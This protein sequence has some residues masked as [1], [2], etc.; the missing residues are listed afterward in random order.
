MKKNLFKYLQ[1]KPSSLKRSL[2]KFIQTKFLSLVL[3]CLFI[4][5]ATLTYLSIFTD[6]IYPNIYI[7]DSNVAF[8]TKS[9]AY[10]VVDHRINQRLQQPFV[11][12]NQDQQFTLNLDSSKLNI[13]YS[14]SINEAFAIG[15]TGSLTDKLTAQLFLF[16]DQNHPPRP[17]PKTIIQPEVKLDLEK[18]FN[19]IAKKVYETPQD[20][21]IWL[22][23]NNTPQI[24]PGQTG[25]ELDK[26]QLEQQIK[27]YLIF[28][29]QIATLP[30]KKAEP[31]F[32]EEEAK[33]AQKALESI[34][35]QPLT[36]TYEKEVWTIDVPTLYYLL[37]LDDPKTSLLNNITFSKYLEDIAVKINQQVQEPLFKFNTQA[38][39]VESFQPAQDGRELDINQTTSLITDALN[40]PDIKQITLPV[41]VVK[42][43]IQTAEIN[44]LGIKELL[45]QGVSHF[46]GS[47]ENRIYNVRLTASK[48][49]G[50]LIPP[51]ETF[52]F[53][54]TV[55]DISAATGFKQAY[56]IK[57]GRTVLDDGGGVCQASTTLFRAAL[58]AGL[59]ITDRTA[60]AYRVSY[61]EQGGFG[62][63][64]DA[65]IFHPTVDFKFKNDTASYILVQA[66][67]E[68]TS[69]YIDLYGTSD[70]R[71]AEV[72]KPL[73]S[74]QTPPPPELRQD[75]PALPRGQ[76][77]Q[78]DWS[79]WGAKVAFNRTV[80]KGGETITNETWR[81]NYKPW[82]AVYLI[83]TKD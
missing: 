83:G 30:L 78:V 75:D 9:Q 35:K 11:I 66:H 24:T 68:G 10:R 29:N 73:I 51:S 60:N 45:G 39:R 70:G 20:A 25:I 17:A 38:N 5:L 36:L 18:Q 76:V 52:S 69:L 33:L 79:A 47:I 6:K 65:T 32:T 2:K 54:R 64:L 48:L 50:T 40:K 61:Y 62:P 28:G 80:T 7:G 67:T 4:T 43:K 14:Q 63:G 21:T 81:S 46:A 31:A 27:E 44:D 22:D 12:S 74:G 19:E 55:G 82:Q 15:H 77:K 57:S 72:T 49:N 37:N 58:N 41:N 26:K 59:P 53:N 56:V 8:L 34:K 42:P 71:V 3:I 1:I 13:N 16:V 23:D